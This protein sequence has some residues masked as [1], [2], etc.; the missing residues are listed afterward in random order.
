MKRGEGNAPF[1]PAQGSGED[2]AH[3]RNDDGPASDHD[4]FWISVSLDGVAFRVV[5]GFEE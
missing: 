1:R 2:L 4:P 3:G 5:L